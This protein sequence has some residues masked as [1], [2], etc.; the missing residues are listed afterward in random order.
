[1]FKP[2]KLR[3]NPVGFAA[4]DQSEDA[5]SFI[6]VHIQERQRQIPVGR[7]NKP[8]LAIYGRNGAY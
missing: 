6:R 3:R 2:R 5:F 4:A 1:M 7:A 8:I